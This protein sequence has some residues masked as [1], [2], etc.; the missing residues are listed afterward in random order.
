MKKL[1]DQSV[2]VIDGD[3]HKID[4]NIIKEKEIL[5]YLS[6]DKNLPSSIIKYI[7]FYQ[8]FV[9]LSFFLFYFVYILYTMFNTIK[10]I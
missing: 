7:D 2:V 5:K 4:E 9:F 3:E 1:H 6:Y 8:R 10:N